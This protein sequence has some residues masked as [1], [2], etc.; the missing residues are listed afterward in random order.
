MSTLVNFERLRLRL[1]LYLVEFFTSFVVKHELWIIM[2][3]HSGGSMFDVIK[4]IICFIYKRQ[5]SYSM[6]SGSI[7]TKN[8]FIQ[9][10]LTSYFHLKA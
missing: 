8:C 10:I 6:S 3:L 5:K 4:V 9:F 7:L 2:A 1:S